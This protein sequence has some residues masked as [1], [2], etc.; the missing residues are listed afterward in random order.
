MYENEILADVNEILT[1]SINFR[2]RIEWGKISWTFESDAINLF[3]SQIDILKTVRDLVNQ[4]RF[5]E[6]FILHRS[7]FENYFLI[8]LM[9]KGI[10]YARRYQVPLKSYKSIKHAYYELKKELKKEIVEG[11]N[12]IVSF[13]PVK[14]YAQI[15]IIYKGLF[16]SNGD[17][18]IPSYYF[19]F[20]E[21][22]PVKH[23]IDKF[24]SIVSKELFPESIEKLQKTHEYL[25]NI[26]LGFDNIL[27]AAILNEFITEEQ[28]IHIK[29]HYNFLSGFTHLTNKGFNLTRSFD[30]KRTVHYLLEL[31]LL[32]LLRISRLY[33][34]LLIDFFLN[35]D[36]KVKNIE[37]LIIYLDEMGKK[38]DYFWFIY[39]QPSEYD[40]WRYQTSKEFHAKKGKLLDE[41]IPYYKDPF[42]RLKGQHQSTI[43]LSTG[44]KYNS[45][46]PNHVR[47]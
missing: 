1:A 20:Q 7:V 47:Y 13:R 22:D 32:Y 25:Y 16:S 4:N 38:Y 44:L 43:E 21:Y 42:E 15:E 11:R 18:L 27:K 34:L 19:V 41:K 17:K 45:P 9:L 12:D 2:K 10:I 40:Y 23:R 6:A 33:L 24:K 5:V 46:W 3:E 31:N 26:Y 29:V 37:E 39:N 8:S 28:K 14:K 35:T 36:H 30:W